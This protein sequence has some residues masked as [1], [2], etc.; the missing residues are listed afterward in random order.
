[1][2][3][4]MNADILKISIQLQIRLQIVLFSNFLTILLLRKEDNFNNIRYKRCITA[5][6]LLFKQTHT[7]MYMYSLLSIY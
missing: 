4:N 7:H 3:F 2:M 5:I 1:M 6:H